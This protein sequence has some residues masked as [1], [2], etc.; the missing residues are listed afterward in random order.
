MVIR[1]LTIALCLT[2]AFFMLGACKQKEPEAKTGPAA[3]AYDIARTGVALGKPLSKKYHVSSDPVLD[4]WGLEGQ[5]SFTCDNA[6]L[7]VNDKGLL[8][9]ADIYVP[10]KS[11][12]TSGSSTIPF[13]TKDGKNLFGVA[14]EELVQI[15]GE[16]SKKYIEDTNPPPELCLVYYYRKDSTTYFSVSLNFEMEGKTV[17]PLDSVMYH[18]IDPGN[19]KELM[20]EKMTFYDW[21]SKL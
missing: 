4:N 10:E 16:P 19:V 8:Q 2:T 9:I 14:Q 20:N 15:Y 7:W 11:G 6:I 12:K 13:K 21:P 5:S 17:K 1:T 18:I 3:L